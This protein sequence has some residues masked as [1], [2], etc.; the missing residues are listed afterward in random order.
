MIE[1]SDAPL[2]G[3][4]PLQDRSQALTLVFSYLPTD[5]RCRQVSEVMAEA[6]RQDNLQFPGLF[7]AYRKGQ[8]VGAT[9]SQIETDKT[10]VFWLP[11]LVTAEPDSTSAL[12]FDSAWAHLL[13]H[14]I[15]F[16]KTLLPINAP[17]SESLAQLG[18]MQYIADLLYL[19]GQ[20]GEKRLDDVEEKSRD[21]KNAPNNYDPLE[22]NFLEIA[23]Y[24]EAEHQR[25]IRVI[26]A[27][28]A[29]SLDC[30]ALAGL[31]NTD[32]IL[33]G[34]R[35]NGVFDPRHWQIVRHGNQ[36]IG[37]LLLADHPRRNCMELLYLG[38]I[39][40]ARGRGRGKK[41]LRLAQQTAQ[42]IGRT[43][44]IAAVDA[45]NIPA[46]QTYM[47]MDFQTWQQRRLYIKIF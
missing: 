19:V 43:R 44:L 15:V 13:R 35:S 12:L 26:E 40:E 4:I 3:Q 25:L 34:Y 9:F 39:P 22:E 29:E 27:T 20:T 23:A 33:R 10:A 1:F 45:A 42:R 46:V 6:A 38:L 8:L 16:A 31:Q 21:A 18:G 28:C 5:E 47:A 41:L 37:C 11:R 24:N 14:R 7:G 30:P 2:I 17:A 32:D 36:D